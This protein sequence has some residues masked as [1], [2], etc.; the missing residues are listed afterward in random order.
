[1]MVKFTNTG[2]HAGNP[3]W[4]N[5]DQIIACYEI[6]TDNGSL[7]TR[8]YGGSPAIEWTVE[9]SLNEATKRINDAQR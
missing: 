8:I 3:I 1:M 5:V 4:L 6:P 2:I 7:T 9:E